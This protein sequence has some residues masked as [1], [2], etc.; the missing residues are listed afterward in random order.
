MMMKKQD[1]FRLAIYLF[2][3][4]ITALRMMIAQPMHESYYIPQYWLTA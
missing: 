1:I 4:F 3:L 2:L